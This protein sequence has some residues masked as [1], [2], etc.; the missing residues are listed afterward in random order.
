MSVTELCHYCENHRAAEANGQS[1]PSRSDQSTAASPSSHMSPRARAQPHLYCANAALEAEVRRLLGET[2]SAHI[3]GSEAQEISANPEPDLKLCR[4]L[5]DF[6]TGHWRDDGITISCD[7]IAR[8]SR[9]LA[10]ASRN[11][12]SPRQGFFTTNLACGARYSAILP[13]ASRAPGFTIRIHRYRRVPLSAYMTARQLHTLTESIRRRMNVERISP[14][15]HYAIIGNFTTI[16]ANSA[17]DVLP[18]P[19]ALIERAGGNA[20]RLRERIAS[21]VGLIIYLQRLQGGERRV[22][23]MLK[24]GWRSHAIMACVR[25]RTR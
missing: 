15:D 3:A 21:I 10:A 11:L 24:V 18:R 5:T 13:P 9:Y 20:T 12:I 25:T 19:E 6:G 14:D 4:V 2:I 8:V 22:A 17:Y 23:E 7:D 1:I 16:H